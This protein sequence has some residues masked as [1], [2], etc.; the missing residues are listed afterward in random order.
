MYHTLYCIIHTCTEILCSD[1]ED[2]D[3][4]SVDDGDN[5]PGTK[6]VY[7]CNDGFR[8]EG[9]P[10]RLCQYDGTWDGEAPACE[11]KEYKKGCDTLLNSQ[12][13]M[14]ITLYTAQFIRVQR[15]SVLT[16]KTQT[17]E[18]WM[19]VTIVLEQKPFTLVTMVLGWKA[20]PNA[21]ANMMELGMGKH[22]LVKVRNTKTVVILC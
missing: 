2:P 21:A 11:G 6:A 12:G 13:L 5:R 14:C 15:S 7:T 4:G 3:N 22:P 19:M 20:N 17:T 8:L 10:K 16:S 9:E 18:V 1:L